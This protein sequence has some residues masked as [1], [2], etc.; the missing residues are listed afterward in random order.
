MENTNLFS[1]IVASVTVSKVDNNVFASF[2][3]HVYLWKNTHAHVQTIFNPGLNFELGLQKQGWKIQP[4][5]ENFIMQYENKKQLISAISWNEMS[6]LI[7]RQN[8]SPGPKSS[9]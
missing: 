4:W 7:R 2:G 8:F 9:M 3:S 1:I 5:T 6:A